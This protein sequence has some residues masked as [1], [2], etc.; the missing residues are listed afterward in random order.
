MARRHN[1][2][3]A[4]FE[5]YLRR[6]GVPYVAVDEAKRTLFGT[7]L[8]KSFDFLVYGQAGATWL[9]DVKGRRFPYTTPSGRR[10]W[11]SWVTW[12]DLEGLTRWQR[13]FGTSFRA[14]FVFAY[15]LCDPRAGARLDP[16]I[17]HRRRSYAFRA[18]SLD[19]YLSA[20]RR[21][22]RQWDTVSLPTSRFRRLAAPVESLWGPGFP[23]GPTDRIGATPPSAHP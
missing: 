16:L 1:H 18:I 10:Y 13:T 11:E 23:N 17:T 3:E 8:V 6:R 7:D 2:Y 22:S 9:I 14:A 19:D 20:C 12:D 4:A 15:W 5:A 21:R